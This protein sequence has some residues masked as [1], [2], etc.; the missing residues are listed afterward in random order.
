MRTRALVL[1]AA[2]TV[3]ALGGCSR[4]GG[5]VSVDHASSAPA[6]RHTTAHSGVLN[7]IET[8]E[9][10]HAEAKLEGGTLWVWFV[11]GGTQTTAAEA[12]PDA[13]IALTVTSDPGVRKQ[14]TLRAQPYALAG[15]KVGRCSRFAVIAPWLEQMPTWTAVGVVHFKGA[16][17][18]L[19]IEFPGGY[20]PDSKPG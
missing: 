7:A 2:L 18:P 13:S 16:P 8:C 11:G 6:V 3:A 15:E 9:T 19:R 5:P 4:G 20:D 1:A 10:G 17:R 14:L 12:V